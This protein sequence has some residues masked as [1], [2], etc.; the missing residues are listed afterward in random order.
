M[1]PLKDN[2]RP[3]RKPIVTHALIA[4]NA[5]V[6]VGMLMLSEADRGLVLSRWGV[7]PERLWSQSIFEVLTLCS[8]M[9]L[10]AGWGH[11]GSN[12]LFLWIFGDDVEDVLGPRR[13][14]AFYFGCGVFAAL[15]H[16]VL[17]PESVVPMVGASGAI[18]GVLAAFGTL[19]PSAPVVVL[20]PFLPL[21]LFFGPVLTLPAWLIIVEFFVVNL[22]SG[23]LNLGAGGGGVAF[24]A[25]LGGFVAGIWVVRWLLPPTLRRPP[26]EL[27]GRELGGREL[28]DRESVARQP[29]GSHDRHVSNPASNA[30]SSRPWGLRGRWGASG[31]QRGVWSRKPP[32]SWRSR[33]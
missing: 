29:T 14:A 12:M 9:F 21:W 31:Q 7:V 18:A 33:R 3:R 1:I 10:H 20:N 2:L 32:P 13:F 30:G 28:G 26:W 22:G 4:A 23:L 8:S 5:V 11:I 19:R 24:F 27:G 16:A 17:A 15:C 25:H 6:F